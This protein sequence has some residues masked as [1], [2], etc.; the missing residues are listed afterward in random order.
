MF[1][2]SVCGPGLIQSPQGALGDVVHVDH[3]PHLSA[4][5]VDV[6]REGEVGPS[7][8][9]GHDPGVGVRFDG[10]RFAVDGLRAH[11][12]ELVVLGR[13]ATVHGLQ[14]LAHGQEVRAVGLLRVAVA[15]DAGRAAH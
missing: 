11:P 2:V 15:V 13:D 7:G 1:T 8:E 10:L 5:A 3:V 14:E 4:A 12:G 6:E 9:P